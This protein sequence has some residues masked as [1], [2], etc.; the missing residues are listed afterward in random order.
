MYCPLYPNLFSRM[1]GPGH[2]QYF[3]AS[4]AANAANVIFVNLSFHIKRKLGGSNKRE[5]PE[6]RNLC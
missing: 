4:N 6:D 3:L 2:N 1:A 5:S